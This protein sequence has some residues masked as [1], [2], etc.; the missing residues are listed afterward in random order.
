MR[1]LRAVL[2]R[3]A[4]WFGRMRREREWNAEFESHLQMHI[5]DNLRAG[6]SAQEARRAALVK[7]GG[8]ESVK[9]SMRDRAT[10]MWI[11]TSWQDIRY[12]LRSL[13]RSLGF[14][15]TAILSLALGLGASLAV[16]VCGERSGEFLR[17]FRSQLA[18]SGDRLLRHP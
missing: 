3:L 6:M 12:A 15:V 2:V 11:D 4:G 5:E 16:C 14:A 8:V 18:R 10:F 9:Q 7:F 13:R 1:R 17:S